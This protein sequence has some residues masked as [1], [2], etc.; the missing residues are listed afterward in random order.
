[1][2]VAFFVSF[3]PKL[4]ETF[5]LDQITGLIDRGCEIDIYADLPVQDSEAHPEV[6][7]YGLRE[8]THE[9][10]IP[11]DGFRRVFKAP[12]LMVANLGKSSRVQLRS[13][14]VF[15]YGQRALSLRL[16]YEAVSCLNRKPYD[17]VHC[18]FGPNGLRGVMLRE[19]G[20]LQAKLITSFYG[21]DVS[22]SA[23]HSRPHSYARLFAKGDLFLA[24]SDTMR[25]RLVELGCPEDKIL[26]HRL[27]VDVKKFNVTLHAPPDGSMNIVTIA[28][29]VH[30]KGIEHGIRAV[31]RLV[32]TGLQVKY[33]IVGD[34]PL[35][36]DLEQLIQQLGLNKVVEMSGWRR[37][38]EIADLLAKAHILLA[39]S[40]TADDGD[41]EG[42]P[43]V[44][45]EALA[46]GLPVVSTQHSGIP[47]V[48]EDGVTGFV[49]PE[50]DVTGLAEK[51]R[52]LAEH[53]HEWSRMGQA[54]RVAVKRLFDIEKLNDRLVEIYNGLNGQAA[55]KQAVMDRSSA[56]AKCDNANRFYSPTIH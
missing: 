8:H 10:P 52:Y 55:E 38:P 11:E 24:I 42:T 48:V 15:N 23:P 44:L 47:E 6:E 12:S 17:I 37:R 7:T 45:M 13:L 34:G 14:N 32:Q 27:G 53:P 51:L 3:F 19:I 21:Y 2:R 26:V 49:V 40:I 1:M 30:K 56:A 35:R 54:G 31:A 5:I 22:L 4:S 9:L 18:H 41:Q 36:D 20:A 28:R 46:A 29:L 16:F 50:R 33:T 43:V 39:P 25:R